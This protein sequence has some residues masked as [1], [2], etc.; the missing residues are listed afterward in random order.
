LG[1]YLDMGITKTGSTLSTPQVDQTDTGRDALY[2]RVAAEYSA[3]LERLARAHEA[4]RSLQQDLL[5]DIHLA[6]WRSLPEFEGRSSLRTWIFRVAHNVAATH[7][8]RQ[9]RQRTESMSTVDDLVLESDSPESAVTIDRERALE[10]L[11]A[12]IRRLKPIDRQLI[13]L[14]LEGLPADEIADVAGLS[15]TNVNTKLHRIRE[16]L[17]KRIQTGDLT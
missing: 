1:D 15:V 3:S 17:A 2:E 7:L 5:Q 14:H 6:L 8:S 11:T 10:L 12:L 13:V 9:K 4:N 16:L